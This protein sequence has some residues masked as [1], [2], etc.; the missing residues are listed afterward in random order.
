MKLRLHYAF[1]IF[2]WAQYAFAAPPTVSGNAGFEHR[3]FPSDSTTDNSAHNN[4]S[5]YF[6]PSFIIDEANSF[7]FEAVPFY[8]LDQHDSKRSHFDLRE[9]YLALSRE[10][11]E[12][13]FG[14]ARVDWGVASSY[15]VINVINQTDLIE[16]PVYQRKLGQPM[17]NLN[18]KLDSDRLEMFLLPGFRERTFAGSRAR[19]RLTPRVDT[20]QARYES[21]AENRHVDWAA[22]YALKRE[23]L[24]AGL[25]YFSGTSRDPTPL[26]GTARYGEQVIVPYYPTV[27]QVGLDA[28]YGLGNLSPKIEWIYRR[29]QGPSFQAMIGGFEY[30]IKNIAGS[31]ADLLLIGEYHYGDRGSLVTSPFDNDWFAGFILSCN[32][33]AATQ[34]VAGDVFDTKSDS[35]TPLIGFYR[36]LG[37][38]FRI[39]IEYRGLV[40]T[41][42]THPLGSLRH[43][44]FLQAQLTFK[45]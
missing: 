37:K 11:V 27:R 6:E 34:L 12:L 20:D 43:D 41:A 39:E 24:N 21:G 29:G 8:R 25:Y 33:S 30:S 17:L 14:L 31:S 15:H 9:F 7:R 35:S 18:Y 44:D 23:D 16:H 28:K 5:I 22:R 13:K 40:A 32:D 3:I 10:D 26:L 1:G 19:L 2:L 45:F 38:G 36:D 4:D 42:E